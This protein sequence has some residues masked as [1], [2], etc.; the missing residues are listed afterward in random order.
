MLLLQVCCES[1][2]HSI[3]TFAND[4]LLKEIHEGGLDFFCRDPPPLDFLAVL[5]IAWGL[6]KRSGTL[7]IIHPFPPVIFS[8]TGGH[9]LALEGL[10]HGGPGQGS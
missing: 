7:E 6:G 5:K 1:L 4:T 3:N 8:L 10:T 2:A 9:V